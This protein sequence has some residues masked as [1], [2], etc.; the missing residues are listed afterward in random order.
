[1]NG[2]KTHF[3]RNVNLDFAAEKV[4][5]LQDFKDYYEVLKENLVA[6]RGEYESFINHG[7]DLFRLLIDLLNEDKV[8]KDHRLIINAAIAYYISP[9]DII[10]EQIYGPSGYID[11]IFICCWVLKQLMKMGLEETIRAKWD[12]A[13]EFDDILNECFDKS[14]KL[15]DGKEDLMLKYV[16]LI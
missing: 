7:P 9:M 16:G 1:M 3:V 15:I 8:K 12:G 2:R 10:P 4:I 5:R 13:G 6:Y 14:L 11:D